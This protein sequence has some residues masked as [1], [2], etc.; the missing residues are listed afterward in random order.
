MTVC[1]DETTLSDLLAGALPRE[2]RSAVMAHVEGCANC[3]R[4]LAAAR[5]DS[6]FSQSDVSS[7][8]APTP[9]ERGATLARYVVLERIGAGAMGVVYAAYDPEL[10]RQVALK[11]LRP[12]GRQV[13]ELR[14]RLVL[15]AQALARLSHANVVSVFDVGTHGDCVFLAMELVEGVTLA[16]WLKTPRTW[17]EVLRVCTDAG[18]GLAAAH[19][20]GLVHRDFKPAN[21]LVG[22]DGRAR[23]T[24]FGMARPLNREPGAT[25]RR[26]PDPL[27]SS[28][29]SPPLTRT[30]ALLGT[31]AYMAPE[32]LTGQRADALSD[33]F[34][35][36]V[37]LHEALYGVRPFEG[38]SLEELARAALEGRVRPAAPGTKVPAWVRRAVLRGLRPRP[39]ERYPSMEP[40]LAALVPPPRRVWARVAALAG[41][42]SLLGAAAVW[43]LAHRTEARCAR[44]TEKLEGVWGRERREQVRAA[45]LATGV[46]AAAEAWDKVAGMLDAHASQWRTLRTEACVMS[47]EQP[48]SNAWQTAACLDARLWQLSAVTDVLKKADARTVRNA[49][50]LTSSLEGLGSC[51]DAPELSTRPQPPDALRPRVDAARRILADTRAMRLGGR[52]ADGLR[53]TSSLLKDIQD[54]D[55]KPLEAEALL[56]HG[57]LQAENGKPKE[58]ED[59]LYKAIFVAE[60]AR[61]DETVAR[62]WNYLLFVVGVRLARSADVERIV[63]H[64]QA[65]VDRLGRERFPEI[66]AVLHLRLTAVLLE[67]GKYVEAEAEITRGLEIARRVYAP[68]SLQMSHFLSVLSKARYRLRKYPEAMELQL[69]TL[70]LRENQLGKGHPDLISDLN[71]LAAIYEFMGR[72]DEAI[73]IQRRA[74]A[75]HEASGF[76]E[77]TL[78]PL[79]CNLAMQ[80]RALGRIEEA[81]AL[82]KRALDLAEQAQGP[83]HPQSAHALTGLALLLGDADRVEDALGRYRE[84]L[85]RFERTLGADSPRIGVVLWYRSTTYLRMGRFEDA[86]RDL[87]RLQALAEKTEGAD[88]GLVGDALWRL[89]TVDLRTGAPRQALA[90]CQRALELH[91][92]IQ[93]L[94]TVATAKA[95]GCIAEA[96]LLLGEPDKALP[97]AERVRARLG[98]SSFEGMETAWHT[99][100]LARTLRALKPP[101]PAR[102]AAMAEEARS[103]FQALGLMARPELEAVM[104][105][106][107][108]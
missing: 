74:I 53:L 92:R 9:L 36:C 38:G 98:T 3:Q 75:I 88:S 55:Y 102:S 19:A 25:P 47:H 97:L 49:G 62:A 101:D 27:T 79:L 33:Q 82:Q 73:A 22:R 11:V 43:H 20:A 4:A 100:V 95:E 89:G 15:E 21:V 63:Q 29:A 70:A 81:T 68:D 16:E 52:I 84:A 46:P 56:A 14:L 13:E 26:V 94:G 54:L 6:V 78:S 61:D 80:L 76:P 77:Y 24:D 65:A 5:D 30:G 37:A 69:Q 42:A 8:P 86:R 40:L 107:R 83:D 41:A 50:R 18:R 67:Q 60:A 17:Q 108:R 66:A 2:Q 93:G 48:E 51:R 1:P 64:A 90:R 39:E 31:P 45:F 32:L 99:F 10:D 12:E 106:Q 44:E 87:L 85:A 91:Q 35:F 58:A 59:T 23:V 57:E 28:K 105:W 7:W 71:N 96:W 104:A 34:S 103:R 72:A